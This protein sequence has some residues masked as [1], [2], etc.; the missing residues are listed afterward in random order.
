MDLETYFEDLLLIKL[1]LCLAE[2][3]AVHL[4]LSE[5]YTGYTSRIKVPKTVFAS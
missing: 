5:H 1:Y 2:S 3:S 4:K